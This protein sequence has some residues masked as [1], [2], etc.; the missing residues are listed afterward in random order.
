MNASNE[1]SVHKPD[2]SQRPATYSWRQVCFDVIFEAETFAGKAFDIALLVI[3]LASILAIALETVASIAAVPSYL[4]IL[5]GFEMAFTVFFGVEYLL[6]LCCVRKPLKYALSFWGIVDLLAF[7]PTIIFGLNSRANQSFMIIRSIRLLR[8]FRILKLVRMMS[9]A[10]VLAN[11]IWLARDKVIVFL[12]VV[13]IAVT[14]SGTLMYHIEHEEPG[15]Q[16]TSIPQSMYWAIVTMTTVGYGDVYPT[17]IVGKGLAAVL[18]LLGYSLIIV[19]TGFVSA[20][21][22]EA[23]KSNRR[24]RAN[25]SNSQ[26]ICDRCGEIIL[27]QDANYCHRCG[28]KLDAQQELTAN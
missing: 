17:T 8:V 21:F 22:T 11:A 26:R 14:I 7:L 1:H 13:L 16:F 20:E 28:W 3:I 23:A 5:D 9:E 10:N 18:I 12:M 25:A 27:D 2:R 15:S 6:R 4:R 24:M 19:P